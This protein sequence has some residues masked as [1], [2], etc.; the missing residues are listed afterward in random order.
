MHSFRHVY[1]SLMIFEGD[2]HKDWICCYYSLPL[3]WL[4]GTD[5]FP[6]VSCVAE[7]SDG[8]NSHMGTAYSDPSQG[9]CL[10]LFNPLQPPFFFLSACLWH[11][12][13]VVCLVYVCMSSLFPHRSS[14][15]SAHPCLFS[16]CTE[17][18]SCSSRMCGNETI[19]RESRWQETMLRKTKISIHFLTTSFHFLPVGNIF[20]SSP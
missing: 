15:S 11:P 8:G 18:A 4:Q 13:P 2:A 19:V 12:N 10:Q 5:P 20:F 6:L 14:L 17:W 9:K 3:H 1:V 16:L 7:C